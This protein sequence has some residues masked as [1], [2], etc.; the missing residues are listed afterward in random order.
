MSGREDDV[1]SHTS[2]G[3][4]VSGKSG[5]TSDE[6]VLDGSATAGEDPVSS[7]SPA[8]GDDGEASERESR[9]EGMLERLR[10]NEQRLRDRER[11][12]AQAQRIAH[13][14]IWE[15]DVQTGTLSW[16]D[17]M[18]R[19]YGLEPG[20][21]IDYEKY[22]SLIH[23]DDRELVITCSRQAAEKGEPFEFCHRMR[24]EGTD[25][26]R[27]LRCEGEAQVDDD[28]QIVKVV[29]IGHD[30][31]E[32]RR[33]QE[34]L[35]ES[36]RK[37]RLLAENMS[38]VIL[39]Q[40]REGRLLYVSPS[41]ER[42]LGYRPDELCGRSIFEL[43]EE[44][45]ADRWRREAY[46]ELESGKRFTHTIVRARRK[47][48]Q[49][50]WLELASKPIRGEGDDVEQYLASGRDVTERIQ[51]EDEAARYRSEL[52][53]RNRELQDF[54]YVASH[55]LQEPL[56]KIRAFSDLIEEDYG[57]KLD[58]EGLEFLDRVQDAAIRMSTLISDLLSFSRVTTKGG[59]FETVD[60]NEVIAGVLSD[61]EVA[62]DEVDAS[63][64]IDDLPE[65]E[66][67]PMQMRQLF[68][69]LIGNAIKFRK[70][71][72]RP[73]IHVR[74]RIM[75]G[76]LSSRAGVHEVCRLEVEDNGMGFDQRYADRIFSPFQR[77]H[78][79]SSVEGTGMGLAICRRIIERHDGSISASSVPEEGTTFVVELPA[80]QADVRGT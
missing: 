60:L 5:T 1:A 55:D 9:L 14:G 68:Q 56:R 42:I 22:L 51:I 26:E 75:E 21:D 20:S 30:V 80:R 18:Y 77:L 72:G 53:K 50:V 7:K 61:L 11:Q 2:R 17:E 58:E 69:N 27:I 54:A 46:A 64:E 36:E 73:R 70:P 48:D 74:G 41:S 52:E 24:R 67:D 32:F 65:I 49:I 79:R 62:I 33:A 6:P 71:E 66:A 12:L 31:T 40:G 76:S 10:T 57:D 45:D 13:L 35:R 8:S 34:E 37:F 63:V 19:I 15:W 47:D 38:D 4:S 25:D 3:A 78:H 28:G 16:S 59:S 43:V 39:L 23:P 29:G 44:S